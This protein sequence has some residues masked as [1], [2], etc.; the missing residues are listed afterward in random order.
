VTIADH[1]WRGASLVRCRPALK[2][3]YTSG[4]TDNAFVDH[5]RLDA[6][7]LLLAKPHRKSDLASLIRIALTA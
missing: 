7:V 5:W 3:L 1:E 6:G 4:Y 2:A